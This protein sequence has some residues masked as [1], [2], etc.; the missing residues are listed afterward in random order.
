M[1][2]LRARF[3]FDDMHDPIKT[4]SIIEVQEGEEVG[5]SEVE[6]DGE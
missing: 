1:L 5:T 4:V 2:V 6:P 3:S